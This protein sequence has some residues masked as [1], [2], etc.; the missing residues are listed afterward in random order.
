MS[1]HWQRCTG[2]VN[3][4]GTQRHNETALASINKIKTLRSFKRQ[5]TRKCYEAVAT[6]TSI[7]IN[8]HQNWFIIPN[9]HMYYLVVESRAR[10]TNF[11]SKNKS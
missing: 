9:A 6:C 7:N 11:Q 2:L 3:K 8:I 4:L 5:L 10:S 1:L